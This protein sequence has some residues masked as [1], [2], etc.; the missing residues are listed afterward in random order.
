MSNGTNGQ[1]G[2]HGN[3]QGNG[4]DPYQCPFCNLPEER[5]I[6]ENELAVVIEDAHPVVPEHSLIVIKRHISSLFE[7]TQEDLDAMLALL[8]ELRA[9]YPEEQDCNVAINNGPNAGQTI[10][11]LHI[12][13]IPRTAGDC[14]NPRGG[15]R[16]IFPGKADWQTNP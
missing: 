7:A 5:I 10:P 6:L 1:G 8:W 12:H 15:I 3:G 13:F 11:H 14:E 9:S 2:G 4:Q 16:A